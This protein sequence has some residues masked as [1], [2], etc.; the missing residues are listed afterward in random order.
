[1]GGFFREFWR[2]AKRPL[3]LRRCVVIA[4]VVGTLL[5]LINEF[6][7]ILGSR[8]DPAL[9]WR[10]GANYLIPFVVSNLG[11]MGLASRP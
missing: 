10:V 3:V 11:A 7:A 6:D 9:A 5:T 8:S 2:S 4:I 1:M